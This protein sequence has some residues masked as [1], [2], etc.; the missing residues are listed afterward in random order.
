MPILN[1]STRILKSILCVQLRVAT[2]NSQITTQ[3]SMLHYWYSNHIIYYSSDHKCVY[4]IQM[5]GRG[6]GLG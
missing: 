5:K 1:C 6:K 3:I 4:P 2:S